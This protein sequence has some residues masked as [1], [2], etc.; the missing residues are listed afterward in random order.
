MI[1]IKDFLR[2]ALKAIGILLF[3]ECVLTLI[4]YLFL[5]TTY[6][7]NEYMIAIGSMI[8]SL[9][10]IVLI[11]FAGTDHVIKWLLLDKHFEGKTIST[12]VKTSQ[13]FEIVI[14]GI[15]FYFIM[16][17]LPDI[18][19][20]IVARFS[21]SVSN[22]AGSLSAYFSFTEAQLGNNIIVFILS[23]LII[24]CRKPIIRFLN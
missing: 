8:V 10:L 6:E 21:E 20:W 1:T 23:L 9:A 18:I 5:A 13:I 15:G 17:S 16:I 4:S 22:N 7:S 2:L 14:F 12:E 24:V 19:Y 3:F 11:F